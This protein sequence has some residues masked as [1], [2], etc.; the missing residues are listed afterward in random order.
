MQDIPYTQ[1]NGQ[2]PLTPEAR[3]NIRKAHETF[4]RKLALLPRYCQ[5]QGI[6]Y[7]GDS[8]EERQVIKR[9][10]NDPEGRRSDLEKMGAI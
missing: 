7:E 6:G 8:P 1:N 2:E 4:V 10:A 5:S 3:D 9:W